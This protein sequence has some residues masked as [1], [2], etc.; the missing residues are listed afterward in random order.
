MKAKTAHK[1]LIINAE[2]ENCKLVNDFVMFFISR[3]AN[4]KKSKI[5]K[6]ISIRLPD[7]CSMVMLIFPS[8]TPRNAEKIIKTG[9]NLEKILIHKLFFQKKQRQFKI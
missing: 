8:R 9:G 5:I 4:V 2:M 6:N 1:K 7:L 3:P